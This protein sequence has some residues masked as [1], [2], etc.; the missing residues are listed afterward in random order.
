VTLFHWGRGLLVWGL[1]ATVLSLAPL[2]LV[3][4]VPLLGDGFFGALAALLSLSIA[5]FAALVAIVGAILL[6]VALVRRR[7]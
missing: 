3:T 7:S 1:V 4:L 6:L 5:P 2:L